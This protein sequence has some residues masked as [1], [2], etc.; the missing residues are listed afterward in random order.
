MRGVVLHKGRSRPLESTCREG[1]STRRAD[2]GRPEQLGLEL[3]ALGDQADD[4][5]DAMLHYLTR[6]QGKDGSWP[7]Y[8]WRPPMEDGVLMETALAARAV[9]LD[10][11]EGR[12]RE[13]HKALQRGRQW[14][15]RARPRTHNERV[16]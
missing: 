16:F 2:A 3:H 15:I 13:S 5:T 9:Q 1:P 11:L 4:F 10:P 12:E 6:I 7:A 14:L 8:D